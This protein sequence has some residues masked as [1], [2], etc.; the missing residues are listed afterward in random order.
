LRRIVGGNVVAVNHFEGDTMEIRTMAI[1]SL[2]P[3][4]YNPRKLLKPG[5]PAWQKLEKSLR[6]FGL[7]EPLIWNET[8]GHVVGGHTRLTI[9]KQLGTTEVPVSVVRMS[10]EREK[11]LN[12]VLNNREAQGRFDPTKL[13]DLLSELEELPELELTGFDE[14]DL[15]ALKLEPLEDE[16]PPLDEPD[17]VEIELS[18][19]REQYEQMAPRLD[20][21]VREFD[22]ECHVKGL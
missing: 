1:E 3:A 11:A 13:A 12:V 22:L 19:P 2:T 7:V 21:L 16:L 18:V 15:R 4:A 14:A 5:D 17:R 9:L 10:P 6:E 20:E 8:T